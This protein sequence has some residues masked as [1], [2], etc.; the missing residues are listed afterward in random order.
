MYKTLLL[1]SWW[2]QGVDIIA[3]GTT[4]TSTNNNNNTTTGT[5]NRA[6]TAVENSEFDIR[7]PLI[8]SEYSL[9][10][11]QALANTVDNMRVKGNVTM[12]NFAC[13]KLDSNKTLGAGSFSKVYKGTYRGKNCAIK[14]KYLGFIVF[15][16]VLILLC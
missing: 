7:Y 14:V 15:Y 6:T 1:D 4:N 10:S 2:W 11:A 8:G 13:I 9:Q 3:T 5:N 16:V 12:L